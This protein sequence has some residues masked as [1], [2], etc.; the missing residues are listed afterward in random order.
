MPA[1]FQAHVCKT[2][3]LAILEGTLQYLPHLSIHTM[4]LLLG[5]E[6]AHANL[7]VQHFLTTAEGNMTGI[8][9]VH[10]CYVVNTKISPHVTI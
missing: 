5:E 3:V 1:Q 8:A 6:D 4:H 7:I 2:I 9:C 10:T